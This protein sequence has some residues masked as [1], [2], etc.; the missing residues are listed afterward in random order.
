M[1]NKPEIHQIVC[2][3]QKGDAISTNAVRLQNI[4]R[5]WGYESEIFCP[6]RHIAPPLRDQAKDIGE[7]RSRSRSG[8]IVL[9]HF[10]IGSETV[11]Y[12]KGLPDRKVLVYHNIT[13]GHF[14]RGLYDERSMLLDQGRVALKEL[15]PVP[16]LS[17]AD[18]GYNAAELEEAGYRNVKVLPI[19][20]DFAHLDRHTDE[21]VIKRYS[22]D[23]RNILFVG[24]I[25]PNKRYE[26][27]IMAFHAYRQFIGKPARLLLVGSY[28]QMERYLAY[29]HNL[30]HE[31]KLKD[32]I[33]T[34]HMIQDR[35]VAHFRVADLFLSMS[36]HEGFCIPLLEAMHFSVPVM[37]YAAAAVPETLGGSG[38]LFREKDYRRIAEMMD[39]VLDDRKIRS[40][41]IAR[42]NERLTTFDPVSLEKKLRG[43]LAQWLPS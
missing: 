6:L 25:V 9:Y 29:L 21:T 39:L 26:H 8:N 19:I 28:I 37:A 11:G 10:S 38:I 2:G 3:F 13:P 15:A 17:L 5:A 40:R 33:F 23:I 27:L 18:S 43:Y 30:V 14:Y 34:G 20:L 32:V 4:F 1:N 41:V 31:L 7:H 16:E 35:L 12:F 22:G 42:Q 24:R 36:E